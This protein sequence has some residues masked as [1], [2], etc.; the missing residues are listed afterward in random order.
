MPPPIH[1]M[2]RMVV[3]M[4]NCIAGIL[5]TAVENERVETL[6]RLSFTSPNFSLS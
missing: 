5:S 2:H 6:F 4:T 3:Y 1:R